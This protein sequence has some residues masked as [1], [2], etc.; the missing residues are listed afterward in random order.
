MRE[1]NRIADCIAVTLILFGLALASAGVGTFG[2]AGA[3]PQTDIG[4]TTGSFTHDGT[5][6]AF[7]ID[8]VTAGVGGSLSVF[9]FPIDNATFAVGSVGT[10]PDLSL[11]ARKIG[12]FVLAQD[13]DPY[14]VGQ[15][16][17]PY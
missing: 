15:D 1:D 13:M 2:L 14:A 12:F 8:N 16:M 10:V 4:P 11:S 3:Q 7:P 17:D 6:F 9:A 5:R